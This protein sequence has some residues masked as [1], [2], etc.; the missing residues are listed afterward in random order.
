MRLGYLS[1]LVVSFSPPHPHPTRT[2]THTHTDIKTMDPATNVVS[3]K[4]LNHDA[5][6]RIE[7]S[8][9]S[10]K[11]SAIVMRTTARLYSL[12]GTQQTGAAGLSVC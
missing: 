2:R 8:L 4:P 12:E 7:V 10:R 5:V 6:F 1:T 9:S 3:A 11:S